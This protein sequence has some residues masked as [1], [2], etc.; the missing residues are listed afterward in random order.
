MEYILYIETLMNKA[1]EKTHQ[2][3]KNVCIFF[4]HKISKKN[5]SFFC[6]Y[7]KSAFIKTHSAIYIGQLYNVV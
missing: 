2:Q 1:S 5:V 4:A 6:K 7:H 3:K